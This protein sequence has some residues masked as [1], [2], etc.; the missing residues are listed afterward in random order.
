MN[1]VS[2]REQS[3]VLDGI[4]LSP[5]PVLSGVPLPKDLF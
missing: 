1:Y 4:N 2:E 5:S 3:V